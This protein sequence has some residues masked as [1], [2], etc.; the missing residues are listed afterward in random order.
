MS[1]QSRNLTPAQSMDLETRAPLQQELLQKAEPMELLLY[2]RSVWKRKWWILAF[3][4]VLAAITTVG[5]SFMTPIY[6]ATVTLLIEQNKAKLVSIEEVYSGVS[7]NREHYQTQAEVLKSPALAMKVIDKLGLMTHPEFDPR[8]RKETYL[9]ALG[10]S[11]EGA[12]GSERTEE[13]VKALVLT[14]F[15]KRI[16]IE[17]VRLTQLVKVSFDAA[18]A[19]LAAR[20]AD[21]LADTYIEADVEVRARIRQRGTNW[22][23]EQLSGLKQNLEGSEQALQ[24]YREREGLPDTKGLAQSGAVRQIEELSRA[25]NEA[26]ERRIEAEASYKQIK[27]AGNNLAS[28]PVV[29]RN[30]GVD[31]LKEIEGQAQKKVVEL[32]GRYGPEHPKMI[33]AQ[34][35]LR[36]ARA[37]T[38]R[39]T[40]D[41]ASSFSKEYQVAAANERS[42]EKALAAAKSG[43][44]YMNRKE[45]QL[46]ALEQDLNTNRQIYEKFM[47]RYR[48]TRAT[49][50]TQSSLVARVVDPAVPPELPY[51][52]RKEQIVALGFVFGI[53][54]ASI[55]ALMLERVSTTVKSSEEVEDKLGLPVLAVLPLLSGGSEAA[56][57]RHYLDVPG[58]VF[59]ESIR[60]ARTSIL[61]SAIDQSSKTLLVTSSVPNE[62]KSA[63]AIN[64]AL[65]HAQ[66]KKT[67]LI[68][69]DL[70]RPSVVR[71]LGLD[72]TRPGLT[73]LFSGEANFLDC[74]Q[75]VE[76]SSLYVLPSGAIPENALEI[77]SS[78]RFKQMVARVSSACEIV[79]IDSPPVHLVSD[80]VVLSTLSTGTIF[81]VRADSTPSP[82]AR[83]CIRSLQEAGGHVLGIALNQLDFK[84][85]DRYYGAYTGYSREY[86]SYQG[87]TA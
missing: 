25:L 12:A 60:S 21:S 51:K 32:S 62:G 9:K 81:V 76:G 53:I 36:R 65:A 66:T 50:D 46:D 19:K 37:N 29:L 38:R 2:W 75:Q 5:V 33:E 69:A 68:E 83:R 48:E 78:D 28:M 15:V 82:V 40:D 22:L 73:S 80:A 23:A 43:I 61:L 64:L 10:G 3:A 70:R 84:K 87:K 13:R 85:A 71:H 30:T 56:A 79:I 72:P 31:R 44:Q 86:G 63:F 55:I 6:R 34:A 54:V 26:T 17:P 1:T 52:P 41:V 35:E 4:L 42:V 27:Q 74:L 11:S 59:S 45:F 20:I 58:S 49:S 77:L 67:L 8:Q 7:P 16:T 24:Q 14:E 57:G 18:D 39:A 47:N